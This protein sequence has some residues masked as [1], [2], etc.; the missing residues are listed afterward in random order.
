[1]SIK[2]LAATGS[3]YIA[4]T[5]KHSIYQTTS[6]VPTACAQTLHL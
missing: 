4:Y 3:M 1:M 2:L 6:L 5:A